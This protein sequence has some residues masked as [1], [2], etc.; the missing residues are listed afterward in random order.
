VNLIPEAV[1]APGAKRT[2]S[3]LKCSRVQCFLYIRSMHFSKVTV[4]LGA[5]RHLQT[6]FDLS[7]I[8]TVQQSIGRTL[9][10]LGLYKQ[11]SWVAPARGLREYGRIAGTGAQCVLP[12]RFANVRLR[13][14]AERG[15]Q[16]CGEP[17]LPF[18][19]PGSIVLP[20]HLFSVPKEFSHITNSD[21]WALK[22]D[23]RKRVPSSG[24]CRVEL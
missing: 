24:L 5:F 20:D 4:A 1:W 12:G 7:A 18:G 3:A 14:L 6:L 21:A 17:F 2:V 22:K 8:T 9:N 16:H 15:F 11:D 13:L 19:N 23:S 10:F